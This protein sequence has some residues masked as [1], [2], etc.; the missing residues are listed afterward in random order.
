M[1]LAGLKPESVAGIVAGVLIAVLLALTLVALH[2]YLGHQT[3]TSTT[4]HGQPL[5]PEAVRIQSAAPHSP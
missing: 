5:P 1:G 4:T 3:I 2:L